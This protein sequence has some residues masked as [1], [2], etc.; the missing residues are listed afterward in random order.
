[1]GATKID[2]QDMTR[3]VAGADVAKRTHAFLVPN[4]FG[5]M[6]A[7]DLA[8]SPE[9]GARMTAAREAAAKMARRMALVA[10][11]DE[12]RIRRAGKTGRVAGAVGDRSRFGLAA[13]S[14]FE[15]K[16]FLASAGASDK[17]GIRTAFAKLNPT[18][19][20]AVALATRFQLMGPPKFEKSKDGAKGGDSKVLLASLRP[21]EDTGALGYAPADGGA[22]S[23]ASSLFERVLKDQPEAFIPPID[24]KDHAWAAT[25]L[26]K[27]AYSKSEQ[28]CLANGIYFEARG[29]SSQGQAAVAQVILNRVRNPAYPNTIC[30]VVYQNKNW[31]N[32]CQFSFACDGHKDRIRDGSSYAEAEDI[33]EKVT[34]GKI[35]IADVGSA[36]HYHATYVKPRWARAMQRVDKIGRHIFY[37]TYNGGW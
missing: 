15:G 11:G 26:P 14:V 3:L 29:E 2:H 32:R 30:G 24:D 4:A 35:W 6:S 12:P 18:T 37:R 21:S 8:Y 10:E 31:R 7:V 20:D 9:E 36:T 27:A 28:T 1:M 33:A 13:G 5:Q 34:T 25:P 19:R 23:R 16:A 22:S 17:A